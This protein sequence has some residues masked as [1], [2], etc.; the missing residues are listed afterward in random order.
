MQVFAQGCMAA[1]GVAR[2]F[3][4]SFK[5]LEEIEL[6]SSNS[7]FVPTCHQCHSSHRTCELVFKL[8]VVNFDLE[9][10]SELLCSEV[11]CRVSVV[12]IAT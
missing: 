11:V 7:M 6:F 8:L 9:V 2:T 5:C 4:I 1:E 3:L 10:E 12:P